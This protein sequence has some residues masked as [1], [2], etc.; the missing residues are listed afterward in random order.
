MKNIEQGTKNIEQ[1]TGNVEFQSG[2]LFDEP[3][4]I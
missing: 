2:Y 3:A 1:G 4:A